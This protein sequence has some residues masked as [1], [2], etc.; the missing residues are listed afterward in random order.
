M[1]QIGVKLVVT[2]LTLFYYETL[3]LLI[4]IIGKKQWLLRI[5]APKVHH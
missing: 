2:M 4:I 1:S 3:E 5:K